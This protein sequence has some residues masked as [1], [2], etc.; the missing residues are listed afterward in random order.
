MEFFRKHTK[1]MVWIL[2]GCFL[3]YLLPSVMFSV[4]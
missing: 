2:I 3:M 1:L 4:R